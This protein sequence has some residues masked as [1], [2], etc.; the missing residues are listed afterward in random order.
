MFACENESLNPKVS[1]C[2]L[3]G[4]LFSSNPIRHLS[5]IVPINIFKSRG[6]KKHFLKRANN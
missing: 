1:I 6:V 5:E 3:F 4:V 2:Y